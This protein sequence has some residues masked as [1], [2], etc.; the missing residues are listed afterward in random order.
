[1]SVAKA[2]VPARREVGWWGARG[3]PAGGRQGSRGAWAAALSWPWSRLRWGL[4]RHS[5]GCT[6]CGFLPSFH[7]HDVRT[8]SVQVFYLS[9]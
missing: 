7:M 6:V 8:A 3:A 5:P 4:I 1:M 2:P 9:L